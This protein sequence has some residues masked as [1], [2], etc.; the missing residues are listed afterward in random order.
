MPYIEDLVDSRAWHQKNEFFE[1]MDGHSKRTLSGLKDK[2]RLLSAKQNGQ[3]IAIED[4]NDDSVVSNQ[5][6][7]SGQDPSKEDAE[8]LNDPHLRQPNRKILMAEKWLNQLGAT[9][10]HQVMSDSDEDSLDCNNAR[11]I[12]LQ[13]IEEKTEHIKIGTKSNDKAD[14]NSMN[15][16]KTVKSAIVEDETIT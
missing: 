8:I 7:L 4:A 1:K 11:N 10:G 3:L 16:F 15:P 13:I 14:R 2:A 6:L 9:R 12:Q 5:K